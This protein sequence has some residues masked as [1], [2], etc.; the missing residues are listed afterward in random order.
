MTKHKTA[1]FLLII[2]I[3]IIMT[4]IAP[5]SIK[6]IDTAPC[7]HRDFLLTTFK[8][9]HDPMFAQ[10]WGAFYDVGLVLVQHW[11]KIFSGELHLII[12]TWSWTWWSRPSGVELPMS[13]LLKRSSPIKYYQLLILPTNTVPGV[14]CNWNRLIILRRFYC[15]V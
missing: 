6:N 11:D 12:W 9:E 8:M 2:I 1:W 7:H 3:I 10:C 14:Q 15:P 5:V 4:S 13:H